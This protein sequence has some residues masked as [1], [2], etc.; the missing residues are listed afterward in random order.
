MI[1]KSIAYFTTLMVLLFSTHLKLWAHDEPA[2]SSAKPVAYFSSESV[3]DVYELLLKYEELEPGKVSKLKLFI[4]D[5]VTNAP[6]DSAKLDISSPEDSSVQLKAIQKAPG[7][8]EVSGSF[9]A[10]KAYSLSISVVAAGG[11]DLLLLQ[12]IEAGKELINNDTHEEHE[13]HWYSSNWFF[14][15]T[16]LISGLVIMFF[17]MNTRARKIAVAALVIFCLLPAAIYNPV[18]AHPEGGDEKKSGGV[19]NTFLVEKETQFLFQIQTAK[20]EQQDFNRSKEVFATIVPAPQGL[21]VVQAPQ[22]GRIISL[23]INVG[24]RVNKGQVVATIEQSIDAGT[25]I[26]IISQKN[27]IESEFEAAKSQYERL[28]SIA[29]I[30]A[31][32]DVTEAKARYESALR[33][34]QLFDANA[35]KTAGGNKLVTLVA[36]ISGVVGTFNYS[37]GSVVGAGQTLCEITNLEKV[38]AEAQVFANDASALNPNMKFT[39]APNNFDSVVYNLKLISAAQNVNS[40]NQSQRVLFEVLNAN[41]Q[42]KIG[43]NIRL[44]IYA[45]DT[46]RKT[47]IPSNAV[48]DVTGKPAVFVKDKAEQ[49]TVIFVQPGDIDRQSLVIAKGIE[50]GEHIVTSNVYQM[51]MI[52]QNQ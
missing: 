20:V 40:G 51:K 52:Y 28:Q 4:S 49:F 2:K 34:K 25:Q 43:E 31:K 6:V 32:K 19:S 45:N 17:V 26:N 14:G 47:V 46:A 41:G 3:S 42:L 9:P 24:Q 44:H 12:N 38:Y 5:A 48:I 7:E 33:N 11:P 36:P 35:G 29:D 50:E 15:L 10:K 13:D 21:A 1:R 22:T 16:G 30:A 27:S 8:Y 23:N 39:A 37:I 18:N